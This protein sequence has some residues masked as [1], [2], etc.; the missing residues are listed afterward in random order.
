MGEGSDNNQTDIRQTTSCMKKSYN[1][2][3]RVDNR[4]LGV[5]KWWHGGEGMGV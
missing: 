1:V 5:D 3:Y 2:G 4:Q